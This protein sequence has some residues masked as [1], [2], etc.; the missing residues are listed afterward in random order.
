MVSYKDDVKALWRGR[1]RVT[2]RESVCDESTGRTVQTEKTLFEDEPC[3][4]SFD[5]VQSASAADGA[6][7]V[8]QTVTLFID[9]ALKIPS[10]SKISVEQNG[11]MGEYEMSGVPA[12]YSA[13]QEIPLELFGGWA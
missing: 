9:A 11:V 6:A 10:G 4:I 5:K 1:C 2:V 3:R 12:V 13:H 7:V 8:A